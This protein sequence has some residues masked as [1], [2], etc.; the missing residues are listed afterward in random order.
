VIPVI[1]PTTSLIEVAERAGNPS[2]RR[3]PDN[4]VEVTRALLSLD[5]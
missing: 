5:A 2:L 3:L 1:V 4:I